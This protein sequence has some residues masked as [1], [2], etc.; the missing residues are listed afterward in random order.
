[1]LR[2]MAYVAVAT[3]NENRMAESFRMR[4]R[5]PEIHNENDVYVNLM[6]NVEIHSMH[7]HLDESRVNA[8]MG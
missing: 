3:V 4:E 2:I 8:P 7:Y 1:M 5:K 6:G